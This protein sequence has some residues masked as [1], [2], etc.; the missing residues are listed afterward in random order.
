MEEKTIDNDILY[1]QNKLEEIAKDENNSK[2]AFVTHNDL[3]NLSS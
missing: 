1:F 2:Y 3:C